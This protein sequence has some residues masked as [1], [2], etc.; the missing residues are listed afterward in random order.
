VR[1]VL[2]TNV[3]VS[4]LLWGGN[5]ER[6]IELADAIVSGDQDLHVLGSYQN[7]QIL[8]PA[9]CVRRIGASA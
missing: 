8:S 3:V 9:E 2:D 1:A 6:L 7:I 5:P 4:G